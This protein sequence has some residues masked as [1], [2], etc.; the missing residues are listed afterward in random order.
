MRSWRQMERAPRPQSVSERLVLLGWLLPRPA[1][2]RHPAHYLLAP[3]VRRWLPQP[4]CLPHSD[5]RQG[6]APVPVLRLATTMLLACAEQ[7]LPL[8]ANGGPLMPLLPDWRG[9][10]WPLLRRRLCQ[11]VA[12]V[13]TGAWLK[14]TT[15][16]Q[17]LAASLGPLADAH[18]HGFRQVQRLP[19]QPRRA[20]AIWQA[21]LA[22]P[23]T[24][25]GLIVWQREPGTSGA[26]C[27]RV[28]QDPECSAQGQTAPDDGGW[29]YGRPSAPFGW[30]GYSRWHWWG[31]RRDGPGR[32]PARRRLGIRCGNRRDR[33][34][35]DRCRALGCAARP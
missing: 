11:W 22:G 10:D 3:E 6:A 31:S 4:R 9:I 28:Q 17:Q 2:P 21:A 8:R 7:P 18:T 23:L 29:R 27:V 30:T 20:A 14:P 32:R 1:T 25:L 34:S 19:W 15:L 16:Y 13:P 24:W 33:R 5:Q 35:P 26:C 12:T